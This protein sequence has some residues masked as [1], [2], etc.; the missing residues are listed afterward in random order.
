MSSTTQ[1][2]HVEYERIHA[3]AHMH[4]PVRSIQ[5]WFKVPRPKW[6]ACDASSRI[7]FEL[8]VLAKELCVWLNKVLSLLSQLITGMWTS[9]SFQSLYSYLLNIS[10]LCLY[11]VLHLMNSVCTWRCAS[12]PTDTHSH[13]CAHNKRHEMLFP[14]RS[15]YSSV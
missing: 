11:P 1:R 7:P 13:A 6:D 14:F 9:H 2:A 3:S 10:V 15:L 12:R 5:N 4:G 8:S